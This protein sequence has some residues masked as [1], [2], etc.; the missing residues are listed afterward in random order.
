MNPK[1]NSS[2][3]GEADILP[4]AIIA[5]AALFFALGI[6]AGRGTT[7]QRLHT[8]AVK[9]GFATGVVDNLGNTT[10]QWKETK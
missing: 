1:S 4:L 10:F 3:R 6:L 2:K 9:R 5:A 8:E 7:E